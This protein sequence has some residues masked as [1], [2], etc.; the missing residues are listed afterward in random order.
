MCLDN[1]IFQSECKLLSLEPF[2]IVG[3]SVVVNVSPRFE[4]RQTIRGFSIVF[5]SGFSSGNKR[6]KKK[7]SMSTST[8]VFSVYT[9]ILNLEL[10]T[11]VFYICSNLLS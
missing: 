9:F 1:L 2:C 4:Q 10:I 6:V 3:L 7:G 5:Q 11:F 8:T